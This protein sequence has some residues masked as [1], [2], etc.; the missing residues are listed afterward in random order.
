MPLRIHVILILVLQTFYWWHF[1]VHIL[2][3]YPLWGKFKRTILLYHPP[4]VEL[5]TIV[6]HL[7]LFYCRIRNI[8]IFYL[9]VL[10]SFTMT[11]SKPFSHI[12]RVYLTLDLTYNFI[13]IMDIFWKWFTKYPK[14]KKTK[15]H[16]IRLNVVEDEIV[17]HCTICHQNVTFKL[18]RYI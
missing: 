11:T 18:K 13:S 5:K 8:F 9:N 17:F 1:L 3:P 7:I 2:Q 15:H 6:I 16:Q 10:H 4:I 12:I 14:E